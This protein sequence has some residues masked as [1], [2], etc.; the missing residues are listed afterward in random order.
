VVFGAAVAKLYGRLRDRK[1]MFRRCFLDF[2]VV[3]CV[4]G[5]VFLTMSRTALMTIAVT[6]VAVML[7][8]A[9]TYKKTLSRIVHEAGIFAGAVIIGFPLVFTSL[10]MIPAVVNDPVRYEVEFQDESFMIYKGDPIDSDKYMTVG[11]FFRA[12]FGRFQT[13]GDTDAAEAFEDNNVMLAYTGNDFAKVSMGMALADNEE[14]EEADED[15]NAGN[16]DISNGR[17]DIFK[18][19]L[20]ALE[21]KGHPKMGLD[22]GDGTEYAHAHNSYLQVAYNFGIIAGVIFLIV[23]AVSLWRAAGLAVTRGRKY[24]IFF[25]PFAL[26]VVFG[27]VSITEWAFHPCIPAGFCFLLLQVILIRE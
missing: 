24:S 4:V 17:F 1:N 7:L 26:I 16:I 3:S 2:F 20:K 14:N 15:E 9:Y 10:R 6:F 12:F 27:F 19:Y 18:A 25:V 11:R 22:K 8:S 23:C 21:L 5:F 13:E